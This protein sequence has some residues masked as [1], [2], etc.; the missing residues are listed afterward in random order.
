ML[1]CDEASKS[2]RLQ[3]RV[4]PPHRLATGQQLAMSIALPMFGTAVIVNAT[5]LYDIVLEYRPIRSISG[6]PSL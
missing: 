4:F 5:S 6:K 3:V 1:V 2:R